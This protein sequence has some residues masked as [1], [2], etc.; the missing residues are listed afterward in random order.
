MK[1]LNI[2]SRHKASQSGFTIIELVVVILLLGILAA[3]ALPRFLDLT[4]EAHSAAFAGINGGLSTAVAM[5]H[6]DWVGHGST[7]TFVEG[8][9]DV[10][11]SEASGYP[12]LTTLATNA[13]CADVFDDILQGGHPEVVA[14][15]SGGGA[16]ADISD[17]TTA[18]IST[19]SNGYASIPTIAAYYLTTTKACAY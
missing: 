11:A 5:Y 17:L 9:P 6:A 19:G 7:G 15:S 16:T 13:R 10:T 14:A 2:Q 1:S 4:D 18:N 3:T 8:S 12:D